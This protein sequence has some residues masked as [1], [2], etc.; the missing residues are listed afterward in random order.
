MEN[1]ARAGGKTTID[2]MLDLL[3]SRGRLDINSISTALDI[4]PGVIED[5]AKI[6]ESGNLV[7][8]NYEFGHM[9]VSPKK[10]TGEE[11]SAV[12]EII[13]VEKTT[14][15]QDIEFETL[16]VNELKERIKSLHKD[17]SELERQFSKEFPKLHRSL[18]EVEKIFSRASNMGRKLNNLR[19]R[20]KKEYEDTVGKYES[21][22]KKLQEVTSKSID[23][24]R[25]ERMVEDAKRF[26][27]EVANLKRSKKTEIESLRKSMDGQVRLLKDNLEKENR[28]IEE[29]IRKTGRDIGEELK[30]LSEWDKIA[31]SMN[32]RL[33]ILVSE[34]EAEFKK[35]TEYKNSASN[36]YNEI[37]KEVSYISGEFNEKLKP[38]SESL[39]EIKEKLSVP[40]E[41]GNAIL[42]A[43]HDIAEAQKEV[44]ELRKEFSRLSRELK[45]VSQN[46]KLSSEAKLDKVNDILQK[47]EDVKDKIT[48]T[49]SKMKGVVSMLNSIGLDK[50]KDKPNN[51]NIEGGVA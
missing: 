31:K 25:M 10:F 34:I 18:N 46:K 35:F 11:K 20:S 41:V 8:I 39:N 5:W 6:L 44:S 42:N 32:K 38:L 43:K 28:S 9:F 26:E 4:A 29:N 33:P 49:D 13:N 24:A 22:Y 16:K 2:S 48:K 21:E 3:K 27:E 23:T 1:S 17:T 19:S 15:V 40:G 36:M 45:S 37:D 14:A 12:S 50:N 51:T 47:N 7:S 30:N